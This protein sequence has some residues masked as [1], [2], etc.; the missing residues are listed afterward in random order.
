MIGVA[1]LGV[2]NIL[3]KT[4]IYGR[5]L[6]FKIDSLVFMVEQI[7]KNAHKL[8]HYIGKEDFWSRQC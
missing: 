5:I 6:Q 7:A 8:T 4:H 3:Q 2:N 1:T